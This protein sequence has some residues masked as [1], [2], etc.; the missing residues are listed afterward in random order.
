[1]DNNKVAWNSYEQYLSKL[2]RAERRR[3]LK[4]HLKRAK[5]SSKGSK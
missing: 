4:Q 1:M 2:P 5:A 3:I